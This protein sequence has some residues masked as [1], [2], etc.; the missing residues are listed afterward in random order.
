MAIAIL[1]G[2]STSMALNLLIL[3]TLALRY[4]RF[5]INQPDGRRERAVAS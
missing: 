3:P 5:E 2:L 1:G 4:A